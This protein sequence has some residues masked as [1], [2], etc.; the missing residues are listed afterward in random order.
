MIWWPRWLDFFSCYIYIVFGH[1]KGYAVPYGKQVL[2]KFVEH[3]LLDLYC[4]AYK[5]GRNIR[6][7]K[8]KCTQKIHLYYLNYKTFLLFLESVNKRWIN[9]SRTIWKDLQS[10][11]GNGDGKL[12]QRLILFNPIT[13]FECPLCVTELVPLPLIFW[14]LW[15]SK[16]LGSSSL[17]PPK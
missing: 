17:T 13:R 4:A 2:C 16:E 14:R 6:T 3:F 5:A 11:D 1:L 10:D 8:L 15:Y 7:W 9:S 12:C